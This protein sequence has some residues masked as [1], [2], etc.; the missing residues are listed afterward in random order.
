MR[1][2][3]DDRACRQLGKSADECP[4]RDFGQSGHPKLP[5][6]QEL[7]QH[8]DLVSGFMRT[9]FLGVKTGRMGCRKI[10]G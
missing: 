1:R 6:L 4:H 10:C 7:L 3:H 9:L 8:T 5:F 2:H